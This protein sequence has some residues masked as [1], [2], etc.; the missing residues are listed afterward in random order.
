MANDSVKF[1]IL[2]R[3]GTINEDKGF[4]YRVEDMVIL[5]GVIKGLQKFRDAGWKFVV[6]TNQAGIAR[7]LYTVNDLHRFHR[8]MRGV[9]G[10]NGIDIEAFCYC[11]HHPD[12]TGDCQCRKPKTKLVE[13]AGRRFGFDPGYS[14]FIGDKDSDIQLGLNFGGVTVLIQ[15]RQYPNVVMPNFKAKDLNQAFELLKQAGLL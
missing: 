5:P 15:N 9:L 13:D 11:P 6:I 14:I 2:D 12:I 3:D 10:E 7:K 1:L 4:I 8:H